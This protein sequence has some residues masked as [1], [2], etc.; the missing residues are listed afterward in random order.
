MKIDQKFDAAQ[1]SNSVQQTIDEARVANKPLGAE[2]IGKLAKTLAPELDK[3]QNIDAAQ[4]AGLFMEAVLKSASYDE[5]IALLAARHNR[6]ADDIRR[7]LIPA[8]RTIAQGPVRAADEPAKIELTT[9]YD[10]A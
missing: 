7:D 9:I 8:L 2:Q 3:L 6:P 10:K 4:R 5:M 1:W